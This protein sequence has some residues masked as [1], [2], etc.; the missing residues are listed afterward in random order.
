MDKVAANIVDK[1]R[2]IDFFNVIVSGGV[3]LYGISPILN[4]YAP[5]FFYVNLGLENN[6][7]KAIVICLVCYI[8]GNAL[9][10]IQ[11]L[12]FKGLK[13]IVVN[14]C[15]SEVSADK[16]KEAQQKSSVLANEYKRADVLAK[17]VKLFTDK[18]LGAFDPQDPAMC[19][20]FF[21]HCELSNSI[22]GYGGRAERL[23]ELATFY[24]QLAVAFYTLTVFALFYM[25]FV[26]TN[27]FLD[28]L[29]Y[30]LMGAIFMGRAY[31]SRLNWARTVLTTYGVVTDK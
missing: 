14:R 15:L 2:I 30:L 4:K 10:S 5:S 28:C 7:E 22:N 26:H 12:F 23:N 3:V 18:N 24:E 9:Q 11:V 27:A 16:G 8:F 25:L 1:L 19:Q 20:Y 29:G 31:Q 13:S 21:D 6:V 17:A